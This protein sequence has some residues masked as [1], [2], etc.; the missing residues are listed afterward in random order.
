MS[1]VFIGIAFCTVLF[2]VTALKLQGDVWWGHTDAAEWSVVSMAFV[3]GFFLV[4]IYT[5]ERGRFYVVAAGLTAVTYAVAIVLSY[6]VSVDFV[7]VAYGLLAD[8]LWSPFLSFE[9][10]S[11]ICSCKSPRSL[12][13]VGPCCRCRWGCTQ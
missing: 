7:L 5:K 13:S 9:E 2:F 8:I 4:R 1:G 6:F 12:Q 3:I 10:K 11:S